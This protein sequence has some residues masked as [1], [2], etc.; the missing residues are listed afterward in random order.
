MA[1]KTC[2]VFEGANSFL[3][4]KSRA[5]AVTGAFSPFP[6]LL[7]FSTGGAPTSFVGGNGG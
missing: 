5:T 2:G 6:Q 4:R 1:A 3:G 7:L